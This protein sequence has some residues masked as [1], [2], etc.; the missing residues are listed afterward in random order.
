MRNRRAMLLLVLAGLSGLGT[1][2][3]ARNLAREPAPPGNETVETTA[4][5]VAGADLAAGVALQSA[6]AKVVEW[7]RRHL[8]T[9]AIASAALLEGRV[10]RRGLGQGEPILESALLPRGASAGLTSLIRN[11]HRAM[12][13]KVDA[14][15]GVA[16]F[17]KPGSRVDVLATV[18]RTDGSFSKVILQN[19]RVLAIDQQMEQGGSG[20]P[21]VSSVVTLEVDPRQAQMLAHAVHQ[22]KL[23]LALRNPEDTAYVP[24]RSI[25][26]GDLVPTGGGAGGDAVEIVR[27]VDVT[28]GYQ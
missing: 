17:V 3:A 22:G 8:P 16:G 7:P 4:L 27:G 25:S 5:V 21:Q 28:S 18:R 6:Q 26:A 15:V 11:Q 2:Y 9:G 20:E 19:V 24:T 23:Q 10:L 13:V 1:V 12:S 14:V